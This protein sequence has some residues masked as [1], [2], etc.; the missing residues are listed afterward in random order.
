MLLII[1]ICKERLHYHEFVR[2]IEDI[3]RNKGIKFLTKNYLE[4]KNSDIGKAD[5]II[6]T[7][8]SLKDNDFMMHLD[9][10]SWLK[11][12]KKPI[13]GI[14]G[15]SHIIGVALGYRLKKKKEIGFREINLKKEFLGV[16]GKLEIY[17]LHQ[18]YALPGV[19]HKDNFYATLF[20]PEV[21]NMEIIENFAK[22]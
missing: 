17:H 21:R 22:V 1:N 15:G 5:K 2:P 10:F 6:I 14:C 4:L 18:F 19:F 11:D 9:K 16:S 20:H 7:G 3:L 8:T 12:F 13:L